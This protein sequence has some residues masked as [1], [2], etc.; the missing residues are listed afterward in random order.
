MIKITVEIDRGGFRLFSKSFFLEDARD[1]I[2]R[3]LVI[4][5]VEKYL[6]ANL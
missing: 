6:E 2:E 5:Q 4:G 3:T 1:K